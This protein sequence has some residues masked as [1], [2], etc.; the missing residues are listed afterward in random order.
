MVLETMALGPLWLLSVDA[1]RGVGVAQA[2]E[3][4][5]NVDRVGWKGRVECSLWCQ[6]KRRVARE[7]KAWASR[8]KGCGVWRVS[9]WRS[10]GVD[11]S[12]VPPEALGWRRCGQPWCVGRI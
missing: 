11:G 4:A 10:A 8:S 3:A 9:E 5:T 6:N 2:D 12:A 7:D 1:Q